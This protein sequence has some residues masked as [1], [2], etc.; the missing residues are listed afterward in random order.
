[1]PTYV[2]TDYVPGDMNE[3]IIAGKEYKM[4]DGSKEFTNGGFIIMEDGIEHCI[5]YRG[6]AHLDNND[7]TVINRP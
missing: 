4:I 1:M 2:K 7:W 5:L 6:C 3:Y